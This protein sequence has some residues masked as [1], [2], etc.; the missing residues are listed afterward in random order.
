MNLQYNQTVVQLLYNQS[1]R[2]QQR[3]ETKVD[4]KGKIK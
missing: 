4:E 1:Y 2:E 3:G